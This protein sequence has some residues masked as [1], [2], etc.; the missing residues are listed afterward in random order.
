MS[1]Q[2]LN[3]FADCEAIDTAVLGW[4][5]SSTHWVLDMPDEVTAKR[6]SEIIQGAYKCGRMDKAVEIRTAINEG[7]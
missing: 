6:T 2:K 1:G 3:P 7:I 5:V 4:V